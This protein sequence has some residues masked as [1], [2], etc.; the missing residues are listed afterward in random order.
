MLS[1]EQVSEEGGEILFVGTKE[2]GSGDSYQGRSS[3]R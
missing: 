3:A 1:S 2:A